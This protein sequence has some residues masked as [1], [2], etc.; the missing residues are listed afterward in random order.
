MPP[1]LL[2]PFA[3]PRPMACLKKQQSTQWGVP[4]VPCCCCCCGWQEGRGPCGSGGSRAPLQ[5]LLACSC[6]WCP[7]GSCNS[8]YICINI[9]VTASSG[10]LFSARVWLIHHLVYVNWGEGEP[11]R[12]QFGLSGLKWQREHWETFTSPLPPLCLSFFICK[13]MRITA[14]SQVF[15]GNGTGSYPWSSYNAKAHY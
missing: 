4:S 13:I 14:V 5:Q 10:I 11:R 2:P 1:G 6:H 9:S 7:A 12:R 15:C 3:P 8:A